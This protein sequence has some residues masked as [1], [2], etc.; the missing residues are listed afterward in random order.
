MKTDSW[1]PCPRC[2]SKKVKTMGKGF[3][4][5]VPLMTGGC[6]LWIGFILWPL[7]IV[8]ATLIVISPFGVF[9]PKMY[10]CKDCNHAWKENKKKDAL[11]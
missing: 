1:E 3:W 9:L 11:T 4:V 2:E 6:L 7:W 5:L 10:Q 8:A